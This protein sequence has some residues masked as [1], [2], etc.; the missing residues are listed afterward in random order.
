MVIIVGQ[1]FNSQ[2]WRVL[3]ISRSRPPFIKQTYTLNGRILNT[4]ETTVEEPVCWPTWTD[5]LSW[6][7][8]IDRI[9]KKSNSIL[10]FLRDNLRS[11]KLTPTFAC[12][13][14]TWNNTL[15][16]GAHITKNRPGI[17]RWYKGELPGKQQ[18]DTETPAASMSSLFEHLQWGS[19]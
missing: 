14:P 7:T 1:K 12:P 10:W 8:H 17:S 6:K 13:T 5:N 18:P 9:S 16:F 2:K 15:L 4:E 19:G 3:R 11:Q